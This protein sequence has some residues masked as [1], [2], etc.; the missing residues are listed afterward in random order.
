MR[1][2]LLSKLL[3]WIAIPAAIFT[4]CVDDA[5]LNVPPPAPKS[6]FV[7]EFDTFNNAYARGW[8][9]QNRSTPIGGF[10][11]RQGDASQFFP[12]FSSRGNRN[13]Y[14]VSRYDACAGTTNPIGGGVL[15][16]WIVSPSTYMK[17]GDKIIFYTRVDVNTVSDRVQVR[18]NPVNDG[19]IVPRGTG[20]EVGDFTTNLLDINPN[21]DAGG[22]AD[23]YPESWTRFE[24]TVRGLKSPGN[25]RFAFRSFI[26]GAGPTVGELGAT[27]GIDSVAFVSK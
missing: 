14:V 16:N 6:S 10:Q 21:F 13:G 27:V 20:Y 25:F 24:A 7:E 3:L 5:Y 11:W 1:R 19:Y 18:L 17:N 9:F 15:S 8:R 23:S 22:T 4:S 12:C 26:P 2:K